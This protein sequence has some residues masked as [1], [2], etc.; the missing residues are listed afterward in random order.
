MVSRH[1]TNLEIANLWLYPLPTT[2]ENIALDQLIKPIQVA[3]GFRRLDLATGNA[4]TF[5]QAKDFENY[6]MKGYGNMMALNICLTAKN[7]DR[8]KLRGFSIS[9]IASVEFLE[10]EASTLK[11]LRLQSVFLLS[12]HSGEKQPNKQIK[13]S[14]QTIVQRI[15]PNMLPEEVNITMVLDPEIRAILEEQH[16]NLH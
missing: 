5:N 3:P 8:V 2:E 9:F 6:Y 1:L 13:T 7:L 11:S 4:N 14:W 15:S 10:N 12:E 16:L